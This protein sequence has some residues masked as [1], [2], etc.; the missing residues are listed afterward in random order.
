MNDLKDIENRIRDLEE[1]RRT[2]RLVFFVIETV[3]FFLL[4]SKLF[5][6]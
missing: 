4:F 3:L 6:H 1:S 2:T 5:G